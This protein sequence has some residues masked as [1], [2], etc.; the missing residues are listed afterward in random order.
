MLS[1]EQRLVEELKAQLKEL[2]TKQQREQRSMQDELDI[3]CIEIERLRA[4]LEKAA[5]LRHQKKAAPEGELQDN[6]AS[7]H[8]KF[9]V[10]KAHESEKELLA[11]LLEHARIQ[12][13]AREN[14]AREDPLQEPARSAGGGSAQS[15][16][17]AESSGRAP[18]EVT[19]RR[20]CTP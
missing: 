6:K 7:E 5:A 12:V 11:A 16:R 17:G 15:L 9:D 1:H 18:R 4:Q 3:Q 20:E 19:E 14:S 13:S 8:V 2:T 10:C